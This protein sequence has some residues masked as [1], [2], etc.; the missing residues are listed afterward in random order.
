MEGTDTVS[1]TGSTDC[2]SDYVLIPSGAYDDAAGTAVEADR[3]CGLGFQTQVTCKEFFEI[4]LSTPLDV[5]EDRDV[6]GMYK[7]A[8]AGEI[9][10]FTGIDDVYEIPKN[11]EIII[12]TGGKDINDCIKEILSKV[13]L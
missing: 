10:S 9:K 1:L 12:N 6:K 8:R 7:K 3:F 11:P 4:Y 5:C 13:S 2:T